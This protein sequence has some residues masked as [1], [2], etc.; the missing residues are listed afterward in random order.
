[1]ATKKIE[2]PDRITLFDKEARPL[3]IGRAMTMPVEDLS[4]S[5]ALEAWQM[6]ELLKEAMEERLKALRNILLCAAERDGALTEKGGQQLEM[7]GA[8]IERQR[9]QTTEPEQKEML[10]LLAQRKIEALDVYDEVKALVYNPSKVQYLIDTGKLSDNELLTLK[11][12][13]Y[14]LRIYKAD[15]WAEIFE[16]HGKKKARKKPLAPPRIQH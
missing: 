11:R 12:I 16:D 13:S 5:E 7:N 15:E 3:L 4:V 2:I 6:L 10:S 9:R 14:A 1:M 8:K